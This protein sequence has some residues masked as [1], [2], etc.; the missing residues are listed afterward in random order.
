[1]KGD[2][3]VFSKG[4]TVTKGENW[5]FRKSEVLVYHGRKGVFQIEGNWPSLFSLEEFGYEKKEGPMPA[6]RD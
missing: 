3:K 5:P 6:M 2:L 1:M 4:Q